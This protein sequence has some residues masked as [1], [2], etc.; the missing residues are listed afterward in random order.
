VEPTV[1]SESLENFIDSITPNPLGRRESIKSDVCAVCL[2]EAKNFKDELSKRE[3]TIS[4]MCQ[5]C[6]DKFFG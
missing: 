1:K 2:K 6:Q 5:E 4:G 3:F